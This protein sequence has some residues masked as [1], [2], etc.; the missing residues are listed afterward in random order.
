MKRRSFLGLLAGAAV[1]PLAK[2]DER[3]SI[4]MSSD[5]ELGLE[6]L[7]WKRERDLRAFKPGDQPV[8]YFLFTADEF[9]RPNNIRLVGSLG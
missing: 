5:C 8:D 2:A 7:A 6:L 4:D 3:R 1:A 9:G